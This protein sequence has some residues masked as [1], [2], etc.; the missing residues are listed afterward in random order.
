MN[1]KLILLIN[2]ITIVAFFYLSILI[3]ISQTDIKL[4]AY[5]YFRY[6]INILVVILVLPIA[7]FSIVSDNY[8]RK[9][10]ERNKTNLSKPTIIKIGF[11]TTY[12]RFNEF[13]SFIVNE[14]AEI[15]SQRIHK[16]KKRKVS[17]EYP[18]KDMYNDIVKGYIKNNNRLIST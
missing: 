8:V 6:S 11:K 17:K 16:F 5:H 4:D 7:L 1:I 12:W 13:F 15:E 10:N 18:F 14:V 2:L 3:K 9:F